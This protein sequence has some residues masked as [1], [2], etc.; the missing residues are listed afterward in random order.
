M[1]TENAFAI[2]V[3]LGLSW[4]GKSSKVLVISLHPPMAI[5]FDGYL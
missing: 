2:L 1:V 5:P 3:M 4:R